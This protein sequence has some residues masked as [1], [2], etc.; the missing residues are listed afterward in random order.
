MTDNLGLSSQECQNPAIITIVARPEE[1][2]LVQVTWDTP[3]DPDQT[4]RAGT[5]VDLHLLN[6]LADSWFTTPY[7]CY[8]GNAEPDW[9]QL[10]NPSDDPVLDIDDINGGGPENVVLNQPENTDVLGGPYL[11]A[12]HYYSSQERVNGADYGESIAQTRIFLNGD[13]AWDY[14]GMDENGMPEPG[15]FPLPASDHFCQ[16]ARIFWNAEP[17]VESAVFCSETRP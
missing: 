13:L 1:A 17:R 7:D 6:P 8:Y 11:V 5:D 10:G 2:I 16:I 12:L 14:T 3:A 9:G 4:D 15:E